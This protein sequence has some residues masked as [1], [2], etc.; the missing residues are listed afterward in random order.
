MGRLIAPELVSPFRIFAV[1]PRQRGRFSAVVENHDPIYVV[2]RFE[3][4]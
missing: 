2:N 1:V 3:G 4:A